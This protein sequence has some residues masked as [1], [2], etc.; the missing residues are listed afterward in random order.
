LPALLVLR[1]IGEPLLKFAL[2]ISMAK[3]VVLHSTIEYSESHNP[4]L[5]E[6]IRHESDLFAAVGVDCSKWEEAGDWLCIDLDTTGEKP[7]AFCNTTSHPDETVSEVIAFAEQWCDLR[8]WSRD[9]QV[10]EIF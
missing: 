6:I 4:V 8:G 10:I 3:C 2:Y 7:G 5:R 9:V 1:V